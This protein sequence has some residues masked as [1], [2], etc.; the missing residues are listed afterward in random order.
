MTASQAVAL[1]NTSDCLCISTLSS[2]SHRKQTIPRR[3]LARVGLRNHAF[4]EATF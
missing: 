2:P 4:D 3:R 1:R